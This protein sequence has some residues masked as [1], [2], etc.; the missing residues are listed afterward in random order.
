MFMA[1]SNGYNSCQHCHG[2]YAIPTGNW[3]IF[4]AG[5]GAGAGLL[6]RMAGA[7]HVGISGH[8]TNAG[9]VAIF[10]HFI[11]AIASFSFSGHCTGI[12]H[13]G[14]QFSGIV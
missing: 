13:T 6:G 5:Q 10:G 3:S 2:T 7:V 4:S 9:L 11:G 8:F 14:I 1:V 12:T